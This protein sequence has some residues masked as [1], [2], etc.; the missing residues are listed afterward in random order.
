MSERFESE[1][2]VAAPPAEVFAYL[3]DPAHLVAHMAKRSWSM[4]GGR[5]QLLLDERRGREPGARMRLRGSMLG[6]SLDLEEE[7][8][9]RDPPRH[10]A[11]QTV[12]LPRLVVIAGYRMGFDVAPDQ[13][14]STLRVFIEYTLPG[15]WL[16]RL[17]GPAY[18]RWCTERMAGDAKRHFRSTTAVG[19]QEAS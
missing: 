11:W 18:A 16:G 3:D 17:L 2:H 15:H 14:G 6:V 13:G 19:S 5:M 12:G 7:V 4:A 8:T 1:A 9:E 10:K